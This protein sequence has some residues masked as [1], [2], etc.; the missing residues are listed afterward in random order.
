M[1]KFKN[2]K[3]VKSENYTLK[4]FL[5]GIQLQRENKLFEAVKVPSSRLRN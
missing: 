4:N 1:K 2:Q 5:S 3:T